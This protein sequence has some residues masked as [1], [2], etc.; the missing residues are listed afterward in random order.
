MLINNLLNIEFIIFLIK[1][2]SNLVEKLKKVLLIYLFN[3]NLTYYYL[4]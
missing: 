2:N 3:N 1:I 4:L